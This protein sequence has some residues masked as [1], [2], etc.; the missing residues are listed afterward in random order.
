MPLGK[1]EHLPTERIE[2]CAYEGGTCVNIPDSRTIYY[3]KPGDYVSIDDV[4]G[5]QK[6]DSANFQNIISS[7]PGNMCYQYE[8]ASNGG[9]V[10]CGG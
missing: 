6:C 2:W 9:I 10:V 3:G 7:D 8:P 4:K 1:T 5:S